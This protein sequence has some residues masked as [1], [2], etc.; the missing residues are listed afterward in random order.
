MHRV[1]VALALLTACRGG[2]H[3]R[4]DAGRPEDA[5]ASRVSVVPKLPATDDGDAALRS[6]DAEIA[7]TTGNHQLELLLVRAGIRGSLDDYRAALASSAKLVTP[8]DFVAW[9]LRVDALSRVHRFADATAALQKLAKLV[10]ESELVGSRATIDDGIG[11]TEAALT[12]RASLAASWPSPLH[13]TIYAAT[14]AEL[15]RF[16]EALALLPKA[17]TNVTYNTPIFINWL[18]FQWGR[19]YEQKGE[20]AV[21][22]DFYIEAHARLPGSVETLEHLVLTLRATGDTTRANALLAGQTHPSLLALAG[23]PRAADEWERYVAALP[24]A[25]ADHAARHYLATKPKRALELA[26]I[27]F[28]NRPN[29]L[30]SRALVVE[31]ALAAGEPAC[32]LVEPLVRAPLKAQRFLAWKALSACGRKAEADRLAAELGI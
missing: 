18:L 24:E 19:I 11:N 31:A 26:R 21:A 5:P 17:T 9:K 8:T 16:D 27:D 15:G 1:L 12:A 28:A 4:K 25:F 3:A 6:L 29:R 20:M 30:A 2:Q 14:L 10:H 23:D 32:E 7:S 13:V 22:R